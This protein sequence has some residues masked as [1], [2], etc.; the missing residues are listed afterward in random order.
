MPYWR[1]LE[2]QN[3]IA[4]FMVHGARDQPG[5]CTWIVVEIYLLDILSEP[6]NTF[7]ILERADHRLRCSTEIRQA[8]HPFGVMPFGFMFFGHVDHDDGT[9]HEE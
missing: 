8:G 1:V 2:L 4:Q 7:V 5:E 6:Q 3:S 9:V